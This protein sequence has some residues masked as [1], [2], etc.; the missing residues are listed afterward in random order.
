[1]L[2]WILVVILMWVLVSLVL[3]LSMLVFA[4]RR[5]FSAPPRLDGP[6]P[7]LMYRSA[8]ARGPLRRAAGACEGRVRRRRTTPAGR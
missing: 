3:G 6:E 2:G 7:P 1:V 8:L 4:R 5:D